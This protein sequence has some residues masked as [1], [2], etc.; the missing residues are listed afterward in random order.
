MNIISEQHKKELLEITEN[1]P[2]D[3]ASLINYVDKTF[4]C[5][6]HDLSLLNQ[7]DLKFFITKSFANQIDTCKTKEHAQN[8]LQE[9][10]ELWEDLFE[11]ILEDKPVSLDIDGATYYAELDFTELNYNN[12][13]NTVEPKFPDFTQQ[14]L[15]SIFSSNI[16]NNHNNCIPFP[17]GI[18]LE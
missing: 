17:K 16:Q 13:Q 8:F 12:V 11:E 4:K 1:F 9:L 18:N 14:E 3:I 15:L 6:I 2:A 7:K 5:H 10:Q